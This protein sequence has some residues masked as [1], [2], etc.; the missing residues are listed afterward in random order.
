M[1]DEA[2][3]D[4]FN[5]SLETEYPDKVGFCVVQAFRHWGLV[6]SWEMLFKGQHDAV[7]ND[8]TEDQ[9]LEWRPFGD[10]LCVF[11]YGIVLAE[12]EQ[13]PVDC[14]TVLFGLFGIV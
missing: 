1:K 8:G 10:S 4:D 5:A 2:Q 6:H 14:E 11:P 9:V 13:G 7:G 3:G 12:D